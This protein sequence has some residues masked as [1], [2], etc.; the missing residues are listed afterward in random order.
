MKYNMK[1]SEKNEFDEDIVVEN[2]DCVESFV[3]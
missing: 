1:W 2:Y 3:T